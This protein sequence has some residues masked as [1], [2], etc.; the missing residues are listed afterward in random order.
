MKVKAA[1]GSTRKSMTHKYSTLAGAVVV[2]LALFSASAQAQTAAASLSRNADGTVRISIKAAGGGIQDVHLCVARTK[3]TE[4]EQTTVAGDPLQAHYTD[5]AAAGTTPALPG[6]WS[7]NYKQV[8]D[9]KKPGE[10]TWC[11]IWNNPNAA[12]P[13]A[14]FTFVVDYSGGKDVK[15]TSNP[16]IILTKNGQ[17]NYAPADVL[18]SENG[19]MPVK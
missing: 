7:Y 14:G 9:P 15:Q 5:T 13:G 17:P 10:S 2:V 18:K 3:E 16:N 12:L 6:G 4:K 1:I 19:P 8:P 11:I